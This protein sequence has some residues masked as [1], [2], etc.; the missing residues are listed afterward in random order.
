MAHTQAWDSTFE[1][2]PADSDDAN[3]GAQRIR[4]LKRDIGERMLEDHYWGLT[5]GVTKGGTHR[6]VTLH[7]QD[8]EPTNAAS[9]GFFYIY[10]YGGV[11]E[12]HFMDANGATI[13]LTEGGALRPI[14]AGEVGDNAVTAGGLATGAVQ[15]GEIADNA[16]T[17]GAIASNAVTGSNIV[18]GVVAEAKL[19]SSAVAQAKLKTSQGSVNTSG[20][21][22]LTLPGGEYG[23]YPQVKNITA[24]QKVT[25]Q[26]ASEKASTSYVTNIHLTDVATGTAYAQQRYV[27]ASGEVFW[28]FILRDRA[29]KEA[30]SMYQAPDHP[31]FGNGGKP[32][33]VSH[34]FGDYDE[35]KH[36][37]I[38]IN[39][40]D[41]ELQ[42]MREKTIQSED[43]P[44]KDLLEIISEEYEI[45]E[46]SK[47]IW[48]TEQVTVGLPPDWDE[49]WLSQRPIEPIKKKLPKPDYILCRRLKLK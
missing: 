14:V 5:D 35:T 12:G 44:D 4:N 30:L 7:Q 39:P 8:S 16:V 25:A 17:Y 23:F 21:V 41:E 46:T 40:T 18:D 29:T 31:C 24:G 28:I 3:E 49:A 6:K 45:D 36:E 42:E 11:A 10:N 20:A 47:P 32:L 19:A 48:P 1:A 38:V 34:P 33:L 2:I 9:T 15:A 22:N 37:I 27:T 26:I 13:R 43:K